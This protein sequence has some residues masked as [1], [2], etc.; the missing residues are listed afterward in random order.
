M[1]KK[2][3]EPRVLDLDL[4]ELRVKPVTDYHERADV[5][6]L[7]SR[8]H[9]LGAN[10]A[11]GMRMCYAATYK[12]TW[13][14][15]LVFDGA[16]RRNKHREQRIGWSNAQRDSRFKY[17]ANNSRFLVAPGYSGVKNLAS[18]ALSL[19]TSRISDDWK[20]RYGVP[21]L[22][23]ETYVD[24]DRNDNQGTCYI[25]AG[26]EKLGLSTGY[27]SYNSDTAK[28]ER[29][30]G[31]WYFLK[32][33]HDDSFKALRSEI[34]HA[35][36]TGAKEVYKKTNNNFVLDAS[37][38]NFKELQKELCKITDPRGAQG[39]QYKF[40]PF[41]SFCIAA[42]VSGYTQYTQIADW[43]KAFPAE[44]RVKFGMRGDKTPGQGAVGNLLRNID[45]QVLQETLNNWLI[46]A[47][48]KDA[49]SQIVSLDGKALRAT[50]SIASEQKAFLNVFAHDLGI[51][52]D[53][54]PTG[55]G[56]REKTEAK[57][58]VKQN[59]DL[60]G[61]IVLA[62]AIHTDRP[63]IAELE[64]KKLGTSSLSKVISRG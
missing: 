12:G 27:S 42:V 37:K 25:A 21:V 44:Q 8:H 28:Y 56:G 9:P 16:I 24:P 57:T 10:K 33:L 17:V 36:M 48:K 46:K 6:T 20:R 19:T 14:A 13:V 50:S 34:P 26:W 51:V 41:L 63:F 39:Q 40:V 32:A 15:L 7:L 43:I 31:K 35:L 23:V 59:M 52:I 64:K 38:F 54:L 29:T 1:T 3:E 55:K 5:E 49:C 45:P 61:K 30:S 53:H 62:D 4:T 22:A 60:E 58:F 47:Y 11:I 2:T 18:K